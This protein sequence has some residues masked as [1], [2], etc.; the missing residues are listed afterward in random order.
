MWVGG[1]R[2][3]PAPLYR[4]LGG[5]QG[6]SGRLWKIS[7]L[8]GFDPR[9]VQ[10][11]ASLY[12]DCAKPALLSIVYCFRK[13]HDEPQNVSSVSGLKSNTGDGPAEFCPIRRCK[14]AKG[15]NREYKRSAHRACSMKPVSHLNSS[16]EISSSSAR[17]F[18]SR[19]EYWQLMECSSY[20]PFKFIS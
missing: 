17:S 20:L 15:G 13:E 12:T 8:S 11:V 6:L 19:S 1:Q 14:E 4:R 3:T 18:I 7:P 2:Q 9:T 16:G 5:L 10:P